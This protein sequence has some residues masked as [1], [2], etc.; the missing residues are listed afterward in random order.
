MAVGE[1]ASSTEVLVVG[2]GPGGYTAAARAAALGKEVTLVESGLLGGA[3]LNNA[4][5]PTKA[6][7][8]WA[9]VAHRSHNH[10]GANAGGDQPRVRDLRSFQ[11]WK[12]ALVDKSRQG[13]EA[14]L[15]R[16]EVISGTARLLDER[17]VA[18]ETENTVT[19]IQFGS[20]V[21]ATGSSPI[22][23]DALTI[24]NQIVFDTAGALTWEEVPP[25]LVVVGGGY[26]VLELAT[27]FAKLG[28]A[29]V[30][31]ESGP[32]VAAEFDDALE[33]EL[34]PSLQALGVAVR[35]ETAAT[36]LTA[37]R[38]VLDGPAGEDTV[39][40]DRI[41]LVP[42]RRPNTV[43]IQ[44]DS[45]GIQIG[46][47]GHV[48]VDDTMETN[49]PGIYAVGD[50][51]DGYPVA[52]KAAAQGRVAAE[53]IGGLPAAFDFEVPLVAFTDPELATVGLTFDE[54]T[55]AGYQTVRGR[56]RFGQSGR[57][58]TLDAPTGYVDI[59]A[60]R[61]SGTV[62]GVHVAG[63]NA[64]EMITQGVISIEAALR[65]EDVANAISPHP[66]TSEL[67]ADAA[68]SALRRMERA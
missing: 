68:R 67:I 31:V 38:L 35:T 58:L 24:D 11:S 3:C 64:S 44:L 48:V 15:A 46:E 45:A 34:A 22:S 50:L 37:D 32:R 66:T 9:D 2:G 27:A 59:V 12:Q 19:H 6:L 5:V 52:H 21:L 60:E 23:H 20:C 55:Q 4:C 56:A 25:R 54:A 49:V 17:R 18:V 13:V 7:T 30:V 40:V 43:E 36:S 26:V 16:V 28:S 47:S 62:L 53:V 33:R 61:S 41:L 57:A 10:V 51:V 14:M 1:L 8:S 65:L 63:R 42:E 39:D 29:V